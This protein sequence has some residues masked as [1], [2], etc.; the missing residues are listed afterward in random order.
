MIKNLFHNKNIYLLLGLPYGVYI[1]YAFYQQV[2]I[3][4]LNNR[5]INSKATNKLF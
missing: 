4:I 3:D 1:N 5:V 2:Q